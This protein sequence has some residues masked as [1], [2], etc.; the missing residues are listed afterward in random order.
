[1]GAGLGPVGAAGGWARGRGGL[2]PPALSPAA[3]SGCGPRG[4]PR[5][6]APR[7]WPGDGRK[8]LLPALRG[9]LSQ[10]WGRSRLPCLGACLTG[11]LS[12]EALARSPPPI[13]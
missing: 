8:G 9:H 5:L 3:P 10:A 4:L 11:A 1:M 13:S 6:P 12:R 7:V 2:I